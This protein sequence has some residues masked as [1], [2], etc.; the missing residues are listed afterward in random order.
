M[1]NGGGA[2]EEAARP[3]GSTGR[4]RGR[5]GTVGPSASAEARGAGP[6]DALEAED[7]ASGRSALRRV[8]SMS[9]P[10]WVLLVTVLVVA[11][12]LAA[13]L[14]VEARSGVHLPP[15]VGAAREVDVE[16]T[17]C[18][19]DVDRL[20]INPRTAEL[21]LEGLL[22]SQGA[23]TASVVVQR[24]DCPPTRQAPG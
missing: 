8:L 3:A 4:S 6:G 21:D 12:T 11:G 19:A 23:R 22:R 5:M 1:V 10:V 2:G 16:M 13:L 18:N 17:L 9:V 7:P 20:E 24:E 15:A 14:V